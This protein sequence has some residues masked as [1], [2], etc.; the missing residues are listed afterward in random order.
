[1]KGSKHRKWLTAIAA[2]VLLFGGGCFFD[3][4]SN[5]GG[6][7]GGGGGSDWYMLTPAVDLM[8]GEECPVTCLPDKCIGYLDTDFYPDFLYLSDLDWGL[9]RINFN[10]ALE[11]LGYDVTAVYITLCDKY[12]CEEV[13]YIPDLQPG[14]YYWDTITTEVTNSALHDYNDCM[15]DYGDYCGM[16]YDIDVYIDQEGT[17]SSVNLNYYFEGLYLF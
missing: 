11:N 13:L 12:G 6:G 2:I 4:H 10:F 9:H 5:D 17:C 16:Y 1:M 15:D 14:E 7:G 3:N 8:V